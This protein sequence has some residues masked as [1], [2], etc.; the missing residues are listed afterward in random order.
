VRKPALVERAESAGLVC[1]PELGRLA[2]VLA[3]ERGRTRCGTTIP[4]LAP[5]IASAL[6]PGVPLFV[7]G[8]DPLL[9]DPDVHPVG[10]LEA[11][12]PFDLV[13]V[14]EGDLAGLLVPGGVAIVAGRAVAEPGLA[15][16]AVDGGLAIAVRNRL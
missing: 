4:A 11:E 1:P 13:V 5:W 7:A 14:D 12:A 6:P 15:S 16:V 2:H 3:A 9:D 10:S 8:G